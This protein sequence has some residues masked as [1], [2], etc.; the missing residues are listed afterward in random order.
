MIFL[1]QN[2]C[3]LSP[4]HPKKFIILFFTTFRG[5]K[6]ILKFFYICASNFTIFHVIL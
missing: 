6:N 5:F 4:W 2:M 3:I 1:D